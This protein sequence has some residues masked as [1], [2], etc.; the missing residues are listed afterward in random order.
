[1]NSKN[2]ENYLFLERQ[3][4]MILRSINDWSKFPQQQILLAKMQEAWKLLTDE[5]VKYIQETM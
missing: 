3:Y 2:I 1:M 4:R 5:E